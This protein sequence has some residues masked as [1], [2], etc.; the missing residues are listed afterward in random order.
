ME[1]DG[2]DPNEISS[3]L[4]LEKN[5]NSVFKAGEGAGASG[6]FFFF[7][8]DGKFLIKTLHRGEKERLLGMLDAYIAYLLSVENK[9]IIAKIYGL[10]TITTNVYSP[11]DFIIM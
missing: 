5:R 3:S 8:K 1:I 11:V 10:F 6:S 4:S 9:S 2:I 7:S